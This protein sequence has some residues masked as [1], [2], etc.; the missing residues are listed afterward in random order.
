MSLPSLLVII[1]EKIVVFE[2]IGCQC[3]PNSQACCGCLLEHPVYQFFCLIRDPE[4]S[5]LIEVQLLLHNVFDRLL[6][7]KRYEGDSIS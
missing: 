2:P 3:L 1:T 6:F 4:P 7:I 5:H